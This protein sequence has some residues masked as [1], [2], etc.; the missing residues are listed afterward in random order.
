MLALVDY[1]CWCWCWHCWLGS[2]QPC[3]LVLIPIPVLVPPQR[4]THTCDG[5]KWTHGSKS[6]RRRARRVRQSQGRD[7][8]AAARCL[9]RGA[10]I[11]RPSR[12]RGAVPPHA[13]G[14]WQMGARRPVGSSVLWRT[15]WVGGLQPCISTAANDPCPHTVL[16]HAP[17]LRHTLIDL[18]KNPPWRAS[19]VR[20][21][22]R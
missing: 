6:S 11:S 18:T 2:R 19:W 15:V 20:V 22:R 8:A 4:P 7:A 12:R 16:C 14:R 10:P 1:W 13:C 9:E 5:Y 21:P 3:V 17:R